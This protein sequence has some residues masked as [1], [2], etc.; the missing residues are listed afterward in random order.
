MVEGFQAA[1][2]LQ[3]GD[4]IYETNI[5]I[6]IATVLLYSSGQIAGTADYGWAI[7]ESWPGVCLS[8]TI[9]WYSVPVAIKHIFEFRFD[10][11]TFKSIQHFISSYHNFLRRQ[12]TIYN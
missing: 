10:N 9:W 2:A 12:R 6:A 5:A 4:S 1:L 11:V 8:G 7:F 3:A